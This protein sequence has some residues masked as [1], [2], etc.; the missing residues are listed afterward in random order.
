VLPAA[1]Q[2]HQT[3]TWNLLQIP[4]YHLET[5]YVDEVGGCFGEPIKREEKSKW[6][7]RDAE[8]KEAA[9]LTSPV[10]QDEVGV[11][12]ENLVEGKKDVWAKWANSKEVVIAML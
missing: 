9:S 4:F 11:S 3:K 2:R 1:C 10:E 5:N 8:V 6:A 7:E 12:D